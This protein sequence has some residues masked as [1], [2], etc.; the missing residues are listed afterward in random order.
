HCQ[1]KIYTACSRTRAGESSTVFAHELPPRSAGFDA[2]NRLYL[3]A[4]T[5]PFVASAVALALVDVLRGK[6]GTAEE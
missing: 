2:E 4:L 5:V 1:S 3:F 6:P